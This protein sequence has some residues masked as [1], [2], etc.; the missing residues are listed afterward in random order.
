[1]TSSATVVRYGSTLSNRL[2]TVLS[3]IAALP[4]LK[5]AVEANHDNNRWWPTTLVDPR[6]RMLVA[7]W[8]TRVSYSMVDVYAHVVT[9]ADRIG[10]DQIARTNDDMIANLVRP[11]GLP[12]AR[13]TYLRSLTAFLTRLEGE[14]TDPLVSDVDMIISR[15]AAEVQQAS[16]KVAQCAM[17]YARGYHCGI[18][19]VD[20]GMVTKL[21]PV[22]GLCLPAGPMAHEHM[23]LRLQACVADRPDDYRDIARTLGY[24]VAIPSEAT[25]TW[26][27][28]LM[29]IYFKRLYLNR[30]KP[31]VCQARP[32][33]DTVIDCVHAYL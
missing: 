12:A 5:A 21:A 31:G 24:Q 7:G 1:M 16:F 3:R 15:F 2:Y 23:R 10:Y 8:S 30:P 9:Q 4:E 18:I 32:V 22:L 26:W 17:L 29:L 27:V 13:L 19:P 33:C 28:H 25:P 20:S 6:M 14:G 11:I